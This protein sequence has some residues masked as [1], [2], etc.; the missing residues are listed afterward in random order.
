LENSL[1]GKLIYGLGLAGTKQIHEAENMSLQCTTWKMPPDSPPT[2]PTLPN[3]FSALVWLSA[4]PMHHRN[5]RDQLLFFPL[6]AAFSR[7][8]HNIPSV[9]MM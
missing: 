9:P 3:C 5:H 6:G 2:F 4:R 1:A 8:A 7:I